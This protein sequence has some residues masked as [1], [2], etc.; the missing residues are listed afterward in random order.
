[1]KDVLKNPELFA[2]KTVVVTGQVRQACT[3]KGCWIELSN[4]WG[5]K[6]Q[7]CRVTFKDYGFFVPLDS[8]GASAKIQGTVGIK[9][10]SKAAVDHYE[11]EGAIFSRKETDGSAYEIRIVATG[12]ELTKN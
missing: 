5:S 8:A 3:K 9:K 10:L 6:A 11:A 1:M 4:S 2:D 7:G 12:V